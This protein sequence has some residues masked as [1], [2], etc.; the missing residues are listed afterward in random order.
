MSLVLFWVL[1]GIA[2]CLM[3][4]LLP[5]QFIESALGISAFI[6]ALLS[7]VIPQFG[8]QVGL[9][10]IFSLA[11]LFLLKRLV[12]KNTP[13]ILLDSTEARTLTSIAPGQSGRVLYEGNSWQARCEDNRLAIAVDQ[14]VLVTGRSGNTLLVLPESELQ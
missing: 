11:F 13:R 6:V 9:W 2:L 1:I 5:T 3:E 8:F 14:P 12:P 7:P 4:L 10:M